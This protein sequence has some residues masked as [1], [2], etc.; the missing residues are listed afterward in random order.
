MAL[1]PR[2]YPLRS[3]TVTVVWN[4][5]TEHSELQPHTDRQLLALLHR[6]N[7]GHNDGQCNE[8]ITSYGR[9]ARDENDS[10]RFTISEPAVFVK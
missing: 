1:R 8:P 5:Q 4:A 3:H 10:I 6:Q 7:A 2:F 9:F